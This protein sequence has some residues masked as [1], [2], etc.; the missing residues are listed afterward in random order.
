MNETATI[1]E[2]DVEKSARSAS[3]LIIVGGGLYGLMLS[4]EAARRGLRPLLLEKSDFSGATSL[5]HLR[6]VHGGLRYL[7][8][9]DIHRFR[10]SVGERRWFLQ[11]FP[12]YVTP[13][14]CLM[15]LYGKGMH[16]NTILQAG[17]ILNDVLSMTRN[18]RVSQHR[19]LP[20]GRIVNREF[21]RKIFPLADEQGLTGGAVW[22]DANIQEYQ[23]LVATL[24]KTSA[25][26]G[27]RALNYV[28]ATALL[29]TENSVAGVRGIDLETGSEY[30]FQAPVVINAAGPWCRNV[31]ALFDTDHYPL[32]RKRLLL[33]NVL[34]DREA[35]S[36]YALGLNPE[37]GKGRTYFFHPWKNRLLVGTGE[38]LTEGGDNETRVTGDDL[39]LFISDLNRAVPGLNLKQEE[40]VRVYSG[41]L[42][43]TEKGQLSGREVIHDHGADNG[44]SGLWSVSGVKFTTSRLVAHKVLN[45]I[46][47]GLKPVS[48][49]VMLTR[50]P[51]ENV[52][53]DFDWR[54]ES[55]HDFA[56]LKRLTETEMVRHVSDLVFRR[57]SLGDNPARLMAVLPKLRAVFDM[58]DETWE[59]ETDAVKKML[60]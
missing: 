20:G 37:K 31:A 56:M 53:F 35:L 50:L 4:Y 55:A 60:L 16:R 17:L 19:H 36:P 33:W 1:L 29:K 6:T 51:P 28:E 23:R 39:K 43:A 27:A 32:F 13:M 46:Y 2:R 3:D 45:R 42:P 49:D 24:L 8:T 26:S 59:K 25:L 34:F 30:D 12:G 10:E 40:A 38:R 9:L 15:P 11:H 41:I 44:P 7:Q 5:N 57:T 14:P 58:S 52:S 47:P 21:I 48:H 54:P 22:Y 18:R